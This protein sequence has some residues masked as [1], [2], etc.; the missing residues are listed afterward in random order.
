MSRNEAIQLLKNKLDPE[1]IKNPTINIR[2]SNFTITVL[3]DV[4]KPGTFTVPNERI[5]ILEAL[6]LAGDASI[7]AERN[8]VLVVR[9]IDNEKKQYRL[10]LRSNKLFTSPAYYLQQNDVVY[11]E[12]NKASSQD[13]AYN[14]NTGL[15]IS[16]GSVLISLI[17]I[18]TR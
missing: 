14:K 13:A 10:D 11:I 15:F 9:E 5:T 1:Y 3:G 6:G 17:A 4:N 12:P 16:L 2:I 18:L 8:N 7:S